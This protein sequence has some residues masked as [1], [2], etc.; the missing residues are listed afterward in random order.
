MNSFTFAGS[1]QV[2][3]LGRV[4]HR[5]A[6]GDELH[7]VLVAGDDHHLE[8]R[9]LRRAA[10]GC[11]SR[12]RPRS[13]S[14]RASGCAWLPACGGRSGICSSRSGG[15]SA[16]L[17]LYS[18]NS[19]TRCVGSPLSKTAAMYSGWVCCL[20]QLAQHVVEDVDG[21]GGKPGGGAHGRRAAARARV[22]GAEDEAER[23]DQE[24]PLRFGHCAYY[25][26]G[27][28]AGVGDRGSGIRGAHHSISRLDPVSLPA[29]KSYTVREP[30]KP[31]AARPQIP[32]PIP[33]PKFPAGGSIPPHT[34]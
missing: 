10:R 24:Q 32:D 22:I 6:V 7:H 18:A 34:Q 29:S 25:S 31:T 1:Y 3:V 23:V 15:V 11:R 33:D 8:A 9:L 4:E 19:S 5:D 26:M 30:R 28:E 13:R 27:A 14:I 20:R 21:F 12:R 2:V 16:R 17:A